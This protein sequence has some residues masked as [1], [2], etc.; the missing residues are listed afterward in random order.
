M[1]FHMFEQVV[2]GVVKTMNAA[3]SDNKKEKIISTWIP[4]LL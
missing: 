1:P 2:D 4:E 3:E